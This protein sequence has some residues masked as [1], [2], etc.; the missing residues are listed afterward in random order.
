LLIENSHQRPL[1]D[2]LM[3]EAPLEGIPPK[4]LVLRFG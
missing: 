4:L 3:A 2:V 1:N